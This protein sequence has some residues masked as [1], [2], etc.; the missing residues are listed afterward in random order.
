MKNKVYEIIQEKFVS[1]IEEAIKGNKILSWEKPWAGRPKLNYITRRPYRGV[2]LF[3]LGCKEFPLYKYN[4]NLIVKYKDYHF[5]KNSP[6]KMN[7]DF[8][9]ILMQ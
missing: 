9:S 1:M 2:N 6:L 8:G 3:L 7:N 4:D 5:Y